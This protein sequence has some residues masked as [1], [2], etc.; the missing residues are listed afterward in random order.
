[1]S[2]VPAAV[3]DHVPGTVHLR[4]SKPVSVIPVLHNSVI[5]F[6]SVISKDFLHLFVGKSEILVKIHIRYGKNIKIVQ[7]RE[8]ALLRHP[9]AAGQDRKIQIVVCFQRGLKQIPDKQHHPVV[10]SSLVCFRQR[11]VIFVD[12]NDH[13]LI[14]VPAQ[15]K[16]ELPQASAQTLIAHI[17]FQKQRKELLVNLRQFC[18]FQKELEPARLLTDH[19]RQHVPRLFVSFRLNPLQADGNDREFSHVFFAELRFL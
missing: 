17:L 16:G 14:K 3:T 6:Q 5:F 10:V 8:N 4:I 13:P 9:E 2:P 18:A 19:R 15:Q 7:S 1:M 11:D 12:E